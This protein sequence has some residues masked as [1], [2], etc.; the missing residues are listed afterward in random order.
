M[1]CAVKIRVSGL[2]AYWYTGSAF[3][4]IPQSYIIILLLEWTV[5]SLC[6][7]VDDYYGVS[8]LVK[9]QI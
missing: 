8:V 3:H 9:S 1:I 2:M 4:Q 5:G 6:N 7:I